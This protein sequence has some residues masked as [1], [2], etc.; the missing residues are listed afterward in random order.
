MDHSGDEKMQ[1]PQAG[2]IGAKRRWESDEWDENALSWQGGGGQGQAFMTVTPFEQH[3]ALPGSIGTAPLN[4]D[5]LLY[6]ARQQQQ[7][8]RHTATATPTIGNLPLPFPPN[9]LHPGQSSSIMHEKSITLTP[10]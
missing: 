8:Y 5:N 1:P 9:A 10:L 7:A 4:R 6:N 2:M 3:A